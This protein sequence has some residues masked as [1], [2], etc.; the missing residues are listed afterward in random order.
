M[1]ITDRIG[2]AFLDY[3]SNNFA[4]VA[5]QDAI[6]QFD[7]EDATF[8]QDKFLPNILELAV[9]TNGEQVGIP[10]S[11]SNPVLYINKDLLRE[12]GLPEEVR[13]PGRKLMRLPEQ[14]RKKQ[15][16]MDFICRSQLT[17][18]LSRD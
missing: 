4:Y 2:W 7:A 6:D 11:L 10:Y 17:F 5:P 16:N 3:F 14:L 8:L 9:N 1:C 13:Q 15:A 12:A 18:G